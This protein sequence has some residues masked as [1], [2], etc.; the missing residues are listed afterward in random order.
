MCN[1]LNTKV[2]ILLEKALESVEKL[3]GSKINKSRK[4][5]IHLMTLSLVVARSVQYVELADKMATDVQEGSNLRRIQRLMSSYEM[6][7]EWVSL[8]ILMLLPDKGKVSL[9]MDRTEWE[10]GGQNHNVL[11]VSVYTHGIGVPIWFECLDN[12]GGNSSVDDKMYV[13]LKCIEILGK[14]RIK[15]IAGDSEFIG[16]EWIKFLMA[17]KII[18]YLDVRSNQYFTHKGKRHQ[19][20]AYMKGRKKKTLDKVTIFKTE[21]GLSIKRMPK[22]KKG[23]HKEFLS[24]V[25]NG[26]AGHALSNYR[27]RWSIEILFEKMKTQG[28]NLEDTHIK[29]PIRLRKLFALVAI[30]FALCLVVGIVLNKKKSIPIKNHGYKA[31]SFFRHGLNFI[32]KALKNSKKEK[33]KLQI[34]DNLNYLIEF[35]VGLFERNSLRLTKIVM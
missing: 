30:A 6:N 15:S 22:R 11:V 7:Y 35:F 12:N 25:T 5:F 32:R 28:F 19:I 17:E 18:F 3:Q 13:I 8:L 16:V 21:L 33:I 31:T 34:M 26:R 29:D 14:A 27:N 24:V 1:A 2:E 23:K 10:F 4:D 20:R 9:S